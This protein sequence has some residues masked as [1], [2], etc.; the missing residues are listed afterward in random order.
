MPGGVGGERSA[1]LNAPYPDWGRMFCCVKPAASGG[2]EAI[3][4]CIRAHKEW[5]IKAFRFLG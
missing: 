4:G 2:A 1:I 5:V 3:V